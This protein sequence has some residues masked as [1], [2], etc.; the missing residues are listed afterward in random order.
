MAKV[1]SGHAYR[2]APR[3]PS[4]ENAGEFCIARHPSELDP[5]Q[6]I[7]QFP[8]YDEWQTAEVDARDLHRT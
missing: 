7:V 6:W 1:V 4:A 2:Y 3:D 5:S 8:G